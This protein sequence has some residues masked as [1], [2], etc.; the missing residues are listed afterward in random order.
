[1]A[2]PILI[3]NVFAT[4]T[5]PIPLSELDTNF[6]T[7]YAAINDY[8]TYSNYL[9]DTSGVANTITVTTP[10]NTTFSYTAG[11]QLQVKVAN[12]TTSTAPQINVNGLGLQNIVNADGSAMVIAQII[13]GQ[14]CIF[15]Y[16]GTAFRLLSQGGSSAITGVNAL[17]VGPPGT[18]SF[19]TGTV[20]ATVGY[21]LNAFPVFQGSVFT[22]N[23]TGCTG[24]VNT[25]CVGQTANNIVTLFLGTGT[26]TSN[27]TTMTMTGLPA[28]IQPA[29]AQNVTVAMENNT[30]F[31]TGTATLN[32]GS[33]TIT[34]A[35]GPPGT[36]FTNVG[37][38]GMANGSITYLLN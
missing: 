37:T 28:A 21:Y 22:G 4:Q 35:A 19:G 15:Q 10:A 7:A 9:V 5:G 25:S 18:L 24:A 2:K 31:V 20:N 13:A 3:A 29:R 34:F 38:K 26:G 36:L 17:A 12:T 32:A 11:V 1:M 16:D 14:L 27:A 30:G 33:G 23:I 6:S 8:A